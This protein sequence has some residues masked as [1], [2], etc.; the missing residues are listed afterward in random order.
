MS[1]FS[2]SLGASSLARM[3]K[4]ERKLPHV[5][6]HMTDADTATLFINDVR[7]SAG[8][9]SEATDIIR[10]IGYRAGD[11]YEMLHPN[12]TRLMVRWRTRE[13][14]EAGLSAIVRRLPKE[15]N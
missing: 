11:E 3:L 10:K 5:V 4:P 1:G 14:R 9:L 13:E 15:E 6:L 2:L 12:G 7:A 8:P